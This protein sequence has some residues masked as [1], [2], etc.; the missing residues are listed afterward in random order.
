MLKI[1]V[2]FDAKPNVKFVYSKHHD[3][4]FDANGS[5]CKTRELIR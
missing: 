4:F 1:T 2:N 3:K 5:S